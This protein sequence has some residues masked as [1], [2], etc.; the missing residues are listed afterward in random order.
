MEG[1]DKHRV[2][3]QRRD[4]RRDAG[5]D[6][7]HVRGRAGQRAAAVFD[8]VD[9]DHEG[10]GN[11]DDRAEQHLQEGAENGVIG[12]AARVAVGDPRWLWVNQPLRVIACKPLLSTVQSIHTSGISATPKDKVTR[13]VARL[14]FV[15]RSRWFCPEARDVTLMRELLSPGDDAAGGRVDRERENE[16]NQAGRDISPG[17]LGVGELGGVVRDL[18]G[19]C[20]ATVED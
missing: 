9:A 17:L 11:R 12:P 2:D 20:L 19:E 1:R 6:V 15:V 18:G 14:F 3:E 16:Q 8:Q 10:D 5:Q 13:T 4:D 7:D